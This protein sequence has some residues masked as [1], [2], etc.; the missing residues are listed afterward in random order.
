MAETAG[1]VNGATAGGVSLRF[2][3]RVLAI[4]VTGD[5]PSK[6]DQPFSCARA[7]QI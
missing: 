6:S 2:R 4:G 1:G 3:G 5:F 7:A